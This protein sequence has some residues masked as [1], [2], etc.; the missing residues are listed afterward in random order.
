VVSNPLC[1]ASCPEL[2]FALHYMLMLLKCN[3]LNIFNK[4]KIIIMLSLTCS[5]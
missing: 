4:E 2:I 1:H 5:I 3:K